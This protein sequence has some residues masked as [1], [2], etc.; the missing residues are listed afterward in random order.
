MNIAEIESSLK[1]LGETPFDADTFIYRF[2]DIYDAPKATVTK[3]R[4]GTTN[5][6]KEPGDLLWK[7]KLFFRVTEKGQTATAVDTMLA[8]PLT[9]KYTPRFLLATDGE[10]VYCRDI[11][12][13]QTQDSRF[14]RLNDIFDFFLPLAGIE[15]YEGVAEN[16]ADIKA[17]ARLAKL[18]DAI[19]EANPE[20]VGNDHTHELNIF[21]TRMLFCFF[22][23]DTSIFEKDLFT[24]T[25]M[26]LTRE[27]GTDTSSVLETVFAAMNTSDKGREGLPEFARRF[28]FVNGGLFHD[29][30]PI[31]KFSKRAR[32]LLKECGELHWK[33]INPDIFGSM[34]QAVVEP[35]MRGDMGMHYTSVPNIMKVLQPLFLMS[36]E[37]EF[38]SAR[39]SEAKLQKLLQRIYNIRVFDPACGSGNFLIIAY[40]ELRKIESRIFARQKEIARQWLLP[41]TG[42]R[43][44]QFFGIE[45]ADFAVET[46]KLSLWI[47]EY[48]MNEQFK[49]QFGTAP[50]ALPL[51]DSGN[52][53]H[54]NATRLDWLEVCPHIEGGETY[55]VGNPPYLGGKKLSSGQSEDMDV[56]GLAKMK[57]LDYIG[58]WFVKAANHIA[59]S[60]SE[61]AFVTTSSVCQ[62]EQVHL[63]WSYIFKK[64]LEISFAHEPFAWSNNAKNN[65]GVF[66]V[67][68]GVKQ[69]GK[70]YQKWIFSG[71]HGRK[72][73][74]IS[75]YLVEGPSIFAVP[76]TKVLT[77]LPPMCMGSNP[78]DGKHLILDRKEY[79]QLI[80]SQPNAGSFMKR[81]MGGEDFLSGNHR[82]CIWIEEDEVNDAC[83]IPFIKHRLESCKIYRKTAGRDAK[84]SAEKPYRF[85]YKTHQNTSAIIFPNT[86]AASRNYVPGGF[87][88]EN[89]VINK[90]A[91]AIYAPD[92]YVLG[93][94]TSTLHRVWLA[95]VGGRLG[96]GYRYSVK[97]VY[98]NFPVPEL[99]SNQKQSLE[100]HT[101]AIINAREAHPGKTMAWLYDPATMPANLLK[102]HQE[103]DDSLEGIYIGRPFKNDVERLEHLFKLY[104]NM[105]KKV[106]TAKATKQ[107]SLISTG[108]A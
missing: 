98:N 52:I 18:Y 45:L 46:A 12:T 47:A 50:P 66:C 55:I 53:V 105:I 92:A 9:K 61:F 20:W 4:Q 60:D 73:K 43:L 6:T 28:P 69:I 33:D 22:A 7:N 31:P 104:A 80:Q 38:E 42:V 17:T 97:L 3:L 44:T 100:D 16:P 63:L 107:P 57:Q 21:M 54:G 87:T 62:G 96:I 103:L 94:L 5:Q 108:A 101:W 2:L 89:T 91:F 48:Q 32:R 24:T 67:I 39:D 85:C 78:V 64:N 65:A 36:L 40:R 70:K 59:E 29:K 41:M 99:S 26:T 1:N 27:D 11:K 15:R 93:L 82:Y 86:S 75:P 25:L 51:R 10:E 49:A 58:C 13:D 14:D 95:A 102:A 34:I 74:N 77:S 68:V 37:D 84:K 83:E 88:D 30:T 56:A 23:E 35:G 79:E 19:L 106:Q 71:A 81:Y 76:S 90:D 72:A 8:D